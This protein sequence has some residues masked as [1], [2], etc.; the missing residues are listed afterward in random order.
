MNLKVSIL[1][2]EPT[3]YIKNLERKSSNHTALLSWSYE[4]VQSYSG[5]KLYLRFIFE[6]SEGYILNFLVNE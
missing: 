4:K 2:I 3:K 5:R 1:K 6:E